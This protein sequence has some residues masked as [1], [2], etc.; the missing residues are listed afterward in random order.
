LQPWPESRYGPG[1]DGLGADYRLI[2]GVRPAA[3]H[4]FLHEW[5]APSKKVV[6]R[7]KIGVAPYPCH[8]GLGGK[9]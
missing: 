3:R 6:P 8:P 4:G 1:P 7:D 9:L 2:E 5:P